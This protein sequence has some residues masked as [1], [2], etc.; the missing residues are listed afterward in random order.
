[1]VT[2]QWLRLVILCRALPSWCLMYGDAVMHEVDCCEVDLMFLST[3][4]VEGIFILEEFFSLHQS[5]R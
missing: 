3:R 1:M 4:R 5:S 2:L